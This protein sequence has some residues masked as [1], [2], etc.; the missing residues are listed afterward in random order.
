MSKNSEGGY[1][2]KSYHNVLRIQTNDPSIHPKI[3]EKINAGMY[4]IH[5]TENKTG[6]TWDLPYSAG[7]ISPPGNQPEQD[8]FMSGIPIPSRSNP[9]IL[10]IRSGPSKPLLKH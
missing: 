4:L 2:S 6:K 3:R 1:D 10:R 5:G 7:C 9:V 8:R